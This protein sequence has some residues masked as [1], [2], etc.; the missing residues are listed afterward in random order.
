MNAFKWV[1]N[2]LLLGCLIPLTGIFNYIIDPY[3]FNKKILI[4]NINVVKEDN[5]PFTI[6]I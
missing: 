3:G 2:W 6:K 1:K 5:T 4:N